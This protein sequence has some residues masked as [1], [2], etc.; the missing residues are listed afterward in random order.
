MIGNKNPDFISMDCKDVIEIFGDYYHDE[1]KRDIPFSR[2]YYGTRKYY[3]DRGYNILIIWEHELK[4][5]E[6][7]L[8]KI[9][10]FTGSHK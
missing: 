9:K 7:V 10:Y 8:T 5:I 1:T 4:Q 6:G 2:T 3:E